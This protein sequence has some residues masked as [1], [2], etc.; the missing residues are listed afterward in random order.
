MLFQS[1]TSFLLTAAYKVAAHTFTT[2]VGANESLAYIAGVT[3]TELVARVI[4]C[5]LI[6]IALHKSAFTCRHVF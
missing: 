3:A 2:A 1:F 6:W 5:I 4:V